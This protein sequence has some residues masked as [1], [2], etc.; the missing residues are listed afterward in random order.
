[1]NVKNSGQFAEDGGL[2]AVWS[3]RGLWFV[4]G[5]RWRKGAGVGDWSRLVS[6]GLI[7]SSVWSFSVSVKVLR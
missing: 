3:V 2:V 4:S 7:V 1:M 6:S 5:E